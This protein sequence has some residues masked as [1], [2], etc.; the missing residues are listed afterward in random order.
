[1]RNKLL[2][3]WRQVYSVRL[4]KDES[5]SIKNRIFAVGAEQ[6]VREG[7]DVCHS[8][9]D[10]RVFLRQE[11]RSVRLTPDEEIDMRLAVMRY[12]QAHPPSGAARRGSS[13]QNYLSMLLSCTASFRVMPMLASFLLVALFGTGVSFAASS[14]LPG[15]LLYPVKVHFNEKARAT[16]L[17]SRDSRAH[18]EAARLELRLEEAA[19]L[20]ASGRLR[21]SLKLSVSEKLR[22]QLLLTQ[23]ASAALAESGDHEAALDLHTQIESDL[24]ANAAVLASIVD[25]SGNTINDVQN[26]LQDVSKAE[27]EVQAR[28]KKEQDRKKA[29]QTD[30]RQ[31]AEKAMQSAMQKIQDAEQ[32]LARNQAADPLILVQAQGRIVVARRV[33]S[34]ARHDIDTGNIERATKSA[35]E[36]QRAALEAKTMLSVSRAVQQYIGGS[37]SA[38]SR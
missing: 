13:L 36:V 33:F 4:S 14:A 10:P 26:L 19:K 16:F 32:Y 8:G 23:H 38:A 5:L 9:M 20:A 21:G 34:N 28:A 1:M 25:S 30:L 31:A 27:R 7:D 35:I 29:Q 24:V 22:K 18:F 12:V 37:A 17:F 3:F 15:D 2:D 11:A 6:P